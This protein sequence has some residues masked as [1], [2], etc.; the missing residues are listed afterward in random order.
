MVTLPVGVGPPEVTWN[1][2]VTDEPEVEGS[3]V[4]PVIVVVVEMD[5]TSMSLEVVLA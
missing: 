3:G 1:S 4:S 2:T 5:P